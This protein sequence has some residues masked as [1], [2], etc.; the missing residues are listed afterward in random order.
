MLTDLDRKIVRY[1]IITYF[2]VRFTYL[3]C[4]LG[5]LLFLLTGRGLTNT[6]IF[7]TMLACFI[8]YYLN[9]LLYKYKF[10]LDEIAER[11]E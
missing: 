10:D 1:I 7:C 3:N 9:D 8:E 5:S 4:I 11:D 2:C 6:L